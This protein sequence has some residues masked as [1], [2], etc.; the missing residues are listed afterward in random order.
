MK[1]GVWRLVLLTSAVALALS[2]WAQQQENQTTY[3]SPLAF[4][5]LESKGILSSSELAMIKQ[6]TSPADADARLAQL[7]VEKGLISQKEYSASI[8]PLPAKYW[9]TR[10]DL[11]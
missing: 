3:N 6:A 7:L 2:A 10:P 11:T 1:K 9:Y 4:L 8:A 5:W